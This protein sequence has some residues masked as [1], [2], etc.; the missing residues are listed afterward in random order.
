DGRFLFIRLVHD[1]DIWY[2]GLYPT[3]CKGPSDTYSKTTI[4]IV[5]LDI[6]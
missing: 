4:E 5:F 6:P 2:S 3:C 1:L